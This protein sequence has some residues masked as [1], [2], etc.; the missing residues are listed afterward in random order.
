[1]SRIRYD[2][3]FKD[4]AVRMIV[5]QG[6]PLKRVAQS[7]GVTPQTL[8]NWRDQR[9]GQSTDSTLPADADRIQLEARVR[10]LEQENRELRMQ[11]EIL[12]KA[13]TF[14]ANEST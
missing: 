6:Q 7:L 13:A 4:E 2:E 14:F 12:K 9:V 8:R 3:T 5:E 1:M 11:R 10:Q